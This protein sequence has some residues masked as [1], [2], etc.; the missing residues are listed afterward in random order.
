MI[1]SIAEIIRL[2]V[3]TVAIG[4][5]FSNVTN[6]SDPLKTRKRF[7]FDSIKTGIYAAAPGIILHEMAHKFVAL[8]YGLQAE[9]FISTIGLGLGVVLKLV[10]SPLI[11]FVPGFVSMP[12]GVDPLKSALIAFVGPLMNGGLWLIAWYILNKSH[13]R[14]STKVMHVVILTKRINGVLFVF[15]LIPLPPFDGWHVLDGLLSA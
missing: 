15:N 2:A 10:S 11:I 5:I 9:F 12:G 1:I 13:K 14:L 8:Y 3:M 7:D 6:L 4:Y